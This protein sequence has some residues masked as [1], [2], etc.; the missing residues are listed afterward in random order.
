MSGVPLGLARRAID[1]AL[2]IVENKVYQPRGTRMR[3][4]PR[5]RLAVAHAETDHGAARSFVYDALD[6]MWAE[7]RSDGT[8]SVST[9]VNLALSRANAFRMARD[10]AQQMVD[11]V[12]TQAI[13]ASSPLDRLL[14]DAITIKQHLV[15]QDRA[16][17]M[18]G[19]LVL[20]Q[21]PPLPVP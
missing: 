6:R 14:R 15:A 1:T 10:V 4:E 2:A 8:M 19:G 20:G 12:G 7:L 3:D 13:F 21:E 18:I 11:T 16:L 9:R 17:E 5:V